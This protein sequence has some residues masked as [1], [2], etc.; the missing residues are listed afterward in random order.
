M[1]NALKE[2][3]D[4]LWHTTNIYMQPKIQEFSKK[5]VD[6]FPGKLKVC[7]CIACNWSGVLYRVMTFSWGTREG[8]KSREKES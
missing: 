3:L 7:T 1:K 2:Q 8:M 6:K 4:K 5:L